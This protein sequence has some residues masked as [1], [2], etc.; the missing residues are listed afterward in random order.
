MNARLRAF[1][2][3]LPSVPVPE[4]KLDLKTK[5]GWTFAVLLLFIVMSFV[6]L[7]GVS[8]SYSLNFEILQVLIASHF[9]S[10]LSL[11]IGPI[12]SASII[13]Q[14]LQGTDVIHIDT[15]TKEGRV[16]FQG[17]QKIAAIS[18]ILIENGVYVFSGA[19]TPSIPG[20]SLPLI[21]FLQLIIAGVIL[22]FMDEV[23]SKWGIGSGISLFILAGIALQLVNTMLNP[24]ISPMGAVPA[25]ISSFISSAPI[26]ALFPIVAIISTIALFAVSIWLQG[27]KVELPLSFGRLRGYSIRW[28][29]AL[30]YT[31]IIPIVLV[32]SL[33]AGVQFFALTL[34]N[35]GNPILGTF[36]H[37]NTLF[38]SQQIATGGLAALLSPPNLQQ[39]YVSA[40]TTGITA[41]EVE[42]MAVYTL[43]LVVGA[44]AFSYVWMYLGGQDPKSVAK[45]LMESGLSMPGFRR[46]ERVLTDIFKRYI[47]PL[48][49]LGG[50]ITGLV[51]ALATL[52]DTL[53]AGVG[54]LLVV[55][56][57]YQFYSS[58]TQENPSEFNPIKEKLTGENV[59]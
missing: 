52:L 40:T 22:M 16:L 1:L 11:G 44:A 30:F 2:S 13:I 54:I 45:Q 33:V 56:I 57:I 4:S 14:M 49:I 48:A 26:D 27:V 32:V 39:L 9:G 29:V 5:F 28:P 36:T 59:E 10:L 24:L 50:A 35:A 34:Y 25:I 6:P 55:M 38:G 53:T 18:F 47:I 20:I 37:A 17:I 58:L 46:D 7:F 19:L 31:S 43:L 41:M 8:K 42:S 15:S 12:V 51:A 23:V 3:N 21:M